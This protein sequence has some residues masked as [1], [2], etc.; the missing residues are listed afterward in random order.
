MGERWV[1]RATARVAPT[2]GLQ[3]VQWAGGQR[4]PPLRRVTRGPIRTRRTDCH[5]RCAHRLRNDGSRKNL[6][7]IPRPVRRLVVGSEPS[8]ASGRGSEVSEWPRSKFPASAVRQRRNF[9]HRNRVIR[10]TPAPRTMRTDC[11]SQCLHWLRNDRGFVGGAVGWADVGIGPYG[12]RCRGGRLCPPG[13]AGYIRC[14]GEGLCPSRGQDNPAPT[15]VTRATTDGRRRGEGKI[16]H[17]L[18]K[19]FTHLCLIYGIL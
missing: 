9:G 7:V 15:G 6:R 8:A 16:F 13:A 19:L 1:G 17:S 4:R 3:V 11:H 18:H 14:V 5:N 2:K 10:N 12:M